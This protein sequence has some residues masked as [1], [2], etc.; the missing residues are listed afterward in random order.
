MFDNI[1]RILAKWQVICIR[2][3]KFLFVLVLII[4][5]ASP[6]G[7]VSFIK[8][9]TS[10]KYNRRRWLDRVG[11]KLLE[12]YNNKSF[13]SYLSTRVNCVMAFL[14]NVETRGESDPDYDESDCVDLLCCCMVRFQ[15]FW[16]ANLLN[17][18]FI[19]LN[20]FISFWGKKF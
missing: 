12:L 8:T 14:S 3:A 19:S 9:T 11:W 15:Q 17:F 18:D 1:V 6:G 7:G 16:R 5:W 10:D 2:S 20:S 13:W 4:G